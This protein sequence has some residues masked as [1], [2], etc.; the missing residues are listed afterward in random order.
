MA[1]YQRAAHADSGV[2]VKTRGTDA[3]RL[4]IRMVETTDEVIDRFHV[5]WP[6]HTGT[7]NPPPPNRCTSCGLL[8]RLLP[9]GKLWK[10]AGS[11]GCAP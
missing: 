7:W 5:P 9:N 6:K 8:R 2:A 10:M 1:H 3:L 4:R 11:C